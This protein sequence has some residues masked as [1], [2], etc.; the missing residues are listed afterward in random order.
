MFAEEG[1]IY[2][3][4]DGEEEEEEEEEDGPE[5]KNKKWNKVELA[6]IAGYAFGICLLLE[7]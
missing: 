1:P 3:E 6:F 2:E 7:E 4:E 5:D